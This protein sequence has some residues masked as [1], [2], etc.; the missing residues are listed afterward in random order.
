M[1]LLVRQ[2]IDV[3]KWV[4]SHWEWLLLIGWTVLQKEMTGPPDL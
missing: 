4:N 3:R 1:F 2:P